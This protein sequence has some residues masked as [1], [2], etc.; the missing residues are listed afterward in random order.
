MQVLVVDDDPLAA[1]MIA[2]VLEEQEYQPLITDNAMAAMEAL[3]AQGDAIGLIVSDMNMPLMSGVELFQ[4]LRQQGN[5]LPFILLTGDDP[6]QARA[7][8]P[9]LDACVVKDFSLDA[10]LPAAIAQALGKPQ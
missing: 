10:S 5:Q 8:E 9:G 3:N 4:E 2:A 6:E 7:L 1:E